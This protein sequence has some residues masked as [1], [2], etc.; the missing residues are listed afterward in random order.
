[1][2][3]YTRTLELNKPEGF[4]N[5]IMNDY[6]QKN[7]FTM[8]EWKGTPAYRAG[9]PMLEGY[10]FLTWSYD[11]SVLK[12]E[13]WLKGSFGGEMG[14][15]GF[16]GALNKKPYKE[17]LEALFVALQQEI[18]EGQEEFT[19]DGEQPF[20][21]VVPVKTVDN[22][23][24]AT[25]ALLFGIASLILSFVSPI[26]AII[27]GG[28]GFAQARMGAGSSAAGKAKVGKILCIIGIVIAIIM[29]VLNIVL[30][31]ATM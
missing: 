13:A 20:V 28:L 3:R 22:T 23:K 21:Q 14:L 11:G 8:S 25:A 17:S 10:K 30:M 29:W 16:V 18:P 9:D 31:T 1:M 12:L 19:G 6:L 2:A 5:Y 24:A 7:Q 15:D 4:V 27:F 26:F